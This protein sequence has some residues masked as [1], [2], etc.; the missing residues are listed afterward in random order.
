MNS[1]FGSYIDIVVIVLM[2]IVVVLIIFLILQGSKIKKLDDR[3]YNLTAGSD[4]E[5]LEDLLVQNLDNYQAMNK[6]LESNSGD[7]RDI[8]R[9]LHSV[10]QKVGLVK[11]D[12][13]SQMGGNLSSVIALLDQDNNGVILNTV[14]NVDGCYSYVKGVQGG[15]SDVA[16]TEEEQEAVNLALDQ[17]VGTTR[18][19]KQM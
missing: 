16:Y 9:R 2:L 8:Y 14:Q 1:I 6:Q 7:I 18:K 15:K 4:G 10:I 19:R 3:L 17:K 5:S 13:F 11:Y 12:A